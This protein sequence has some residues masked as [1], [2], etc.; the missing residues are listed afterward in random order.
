MVFVEGQSGHRIEQSGLHI[1]LSVNWQTGKL[2]AH[3]EQRIYWA[4]HVLH[5]HV[6][7]VYYVE[8]RYLGLVAS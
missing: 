1:Y 8:V 7:A 4:L 5:V 6:V 3:S 2:A